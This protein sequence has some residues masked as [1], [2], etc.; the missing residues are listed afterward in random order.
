MKSEGDSG[1]SLGGGFVENYDLCFF[2]VN[3]H[4]ASL[5]PVLVGIHHRLG[6]KNFFM[7]SRI[8]FRV[9]RIA[10]AL[11]SRSSLSDFV[12]S[13]ILVSRSGMPVVARKIGDFYQVGNGRG[14]ERKCKSCCGLFVPGISGL[15]FRQWLG[16]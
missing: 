4:T 2:V 7:F 9:G 5:C 14:K 15:V 16:E 6:G 10:A 11:R 13:H 12:C 3:A 1:G 8:S